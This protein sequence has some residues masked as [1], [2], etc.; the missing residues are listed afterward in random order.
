MDSEDK[1]T[2]GE[3]IELEFKRIPNEDCTKCL[4]ASV[5]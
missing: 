5:R 2:S 4:C 1:I 3:T